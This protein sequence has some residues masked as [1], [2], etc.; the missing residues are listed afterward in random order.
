[1]LKLIQGCQKPNIAYFVILFS[2]ACNLQLVEVSDRSVIRSERRSVDLNHRERRISI[3]S[4]YEV[5]RPYRGLTVADLRSVV[6][7]VS[8]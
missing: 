8:R 5:D 3:V 6:L 2:R 7:T 1:M 4:T